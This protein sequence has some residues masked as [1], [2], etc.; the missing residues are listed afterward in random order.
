MRNL[1]SPGRSPVFAERGMIATSHPLATAAGMEALKAGGTAADAAIAAVAVMSV[2]EPQMTGI[3]GDCFTLI[4]K[5]GAPI[6]GYNGSGRAPKALNAALLRDKGLSSIDLN[7]AH[8]VTVPGAVEAWEVILNTHGKLGLERALQSA[9]HYAEQGWHV[10]ERVAFDFGECAARLRGNETAS[11]IYLKNGEPYAHGDKITNPELAKTLKIIAK[12]GAKGFY[13]GE[14]A[15]DI[16]T[17]LNKLGG[18]MTMED[19]ATHKGSVEKPITSSY[20]G[21]EIAELPPNGQGITALILLNILENFTPAAHDSALRY[22][23]ANEAS[24]LAYA[25]RDQHVAERSSMKTTPEQLLDKG[26][27]KRLAA[28]I[29][30]DKR[31][32]QLI[33][34]P[35][36]TDTIYLACVD[37]NGMA[38][39]FI[40]SVFHSF[41]SCIVSEKTGI[42]LQNRGAAFSL[43]EGHPNELAGGKRPMHTIIPAMM[44]ENGLVS[45]FGVMGGAY[46]ATGHAHV[47]QNMVDY[48]MSPQAALDAP[49]SFFEG[50]LTTIENTFTAEQRQGLEQRGH[51]LKEQKGP[52][53]GGQII[54]RLASGVMVAG[55]DSRKDGHAQGY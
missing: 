6:W 18:L 25:V 27:A 15:A 23:L 38:V 49:R 2:V 51:V 3:G 48:G 12:M 42:A 44:I 13:E 22:H 55:S 40:N 24:R 19:L 8:S 46:Q 21:V 17:S 30:P 1:H 50:D 28:M 47:V 36:G 26:F 53:G 16:V 4:S 35:P 34:P 52:I 45:P 39:S 9:I 54:R 20:R 33:P 41:G 31:S 11:R 5:P 32:E 7:S 43:A 14:V 37:E 10:A 29:N